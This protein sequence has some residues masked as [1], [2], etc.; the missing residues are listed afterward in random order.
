MRILLAGQ[1]VAAIIFNILRLSFFYD[2]QMPMSV[3]MFLTVFIGVGLSVLIFSIFFVQ[4]ENNEFS[5]QKN[6]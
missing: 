3:A 5:Q 4:Q 1:I 2:R 6:A